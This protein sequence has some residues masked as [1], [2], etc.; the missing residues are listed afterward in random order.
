MP[1]YIVRRRIHDGSAGHEPGDIL[2]DDAVAGW[3]NLRSL[4][5]AGFLQEV[6]D[7]PPAPA[8]STAPARGG[9]DRGPLRLNVEALR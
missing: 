2:S 3:R 9:G 5:S 1:R 7:L 8:R 6:P 4:V